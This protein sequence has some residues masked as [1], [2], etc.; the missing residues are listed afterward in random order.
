MSDG[1]EMSMTEI[2][3]ANALECM[4]RLWKE[5][6]VSQN[7]VRD[8]LRTIGGHLTDATMA[9]KSEAAVARTMFAL[10]TTM[11]PKRQRRKAA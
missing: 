11:K 2:H 8:Y 5:E 9:S 1:T 3:I 7:M 6:R 10:T 4:R